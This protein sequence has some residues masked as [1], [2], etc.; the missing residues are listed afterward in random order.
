M[1]VAKVTVSIES[2][3]LNQ[4]DRLVKERVF[5]N[6]SQAFQVAVGEKLARLNKTRLARACEMLD[7]LEEK[8]LAEVGV[9]FDLTEWPEY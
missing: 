5:P 3:V 2:D 7:P 8:Q 1:S 9:N 4:L 6:R